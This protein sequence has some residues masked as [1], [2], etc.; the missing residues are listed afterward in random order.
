MLLASALAMRCASS[1]AWMPENTEPLDWVVIAVDWVMTLLGE[2]D[3]KTFS[4]I[5]LKKKLAF[6]FESIRSKLMLH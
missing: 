3:A 1:N 2:F 5:W 4:F 6:D